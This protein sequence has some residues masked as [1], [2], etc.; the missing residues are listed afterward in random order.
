MSEHAHDLRRGA[1]PAEG[2]GGRERAGDRGGPPGVGDTGG[3]DTGEHGARG[4]GGAGASCA[5]C[6]ARLGEGSERCPACGL[7]RGSTRDPVSRATLLRV[8]LAFAALY[9]VVLVVVALAR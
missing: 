1:S 6:D 9:A 8:G 5:L 3:G 7:W 2:D 4:E